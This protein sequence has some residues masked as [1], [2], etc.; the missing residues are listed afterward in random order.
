MIYLKK[1]E[2]E[3]INIFFIINPRIRFETTTKP[4]YTQAIMF[5]QY[6]GY[7]VLI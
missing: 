6:K 5:S 7:F 4:L 1:L 3:N 2:K